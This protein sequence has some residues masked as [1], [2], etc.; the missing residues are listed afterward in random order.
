MDKFIKDPIS[1]LDY[2]VDWSKWLDG[3]TIIESEWAKNGDGILID[4]H[5]H[6]D[7][8][9]VVWVAGG[10]EGTRYILTNRIT[11]ASGRVDERSIGINIVN[12]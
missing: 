9:T 2:R 11:T 12:R 10:D 5:T 1:T 8:V 4:S 3:D 6:S 7:S